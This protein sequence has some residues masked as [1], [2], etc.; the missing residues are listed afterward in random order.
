MLF[1]ALAAVQTVLSVGT[2]QAIEQNWIM[3]TLIETTGMTGAIAIKMAIPIVAFL[4]ARALITRDSGWTPW[5][6]RAFGAGAIMYALDAAGNLYAMTQGAYPDSHL[7]GVE[8]ALVGVALVCSFGAIVLTRTHLTVAGEGVRTHAKP[9]GIVVLVGMLVFAPATGAININASSPVGTATASSG[10]TEVSTY[11]PSD[12]NFVAHFT[13]DGSEVHHRIYD[14]SDNNYVR[15]D[16]TDGSVIGSTVDNSFHGIYETGGGLNYAYADDSAGDRGIAAYDNDGNRVWEQAG[17]VGAS[18]PLNFIEYGESSD[19]VYFEQTDSNNNGGMT[20]VDATDGTV[21][22]ENS[23]SPESLDQHPDTGYLWTIDNSD[24]VRKVDPA[25]GS[26]LNSYALSSSV[27]TTHSAA[28]DTERDNFWITN[29]NGD[30]YKVPLGGTS[31]TEVYTNADSQT[32]TN[33]IRQ[34]IKYSSTADRMYFVSGND[35]GDID[36]TDESVQATTAS[37]QPQQISI[38]E[39][40]GEIQ[41]AVKFGSVKTTVFSTGVETTDGVSGTVTSCDATTYVADKSQCEDTPVADTTVEVIAVQKSELSPDAGES[42]KEAA[43]EKLQQAKNPLPPSWDA[44]LQ[45][46]GNGGFFENQN[47]EY[48]AIHTRDDW[49]MSGWTNDANLEEPMVNPP[50]NEEIVLSAWDPSKN[51]IAQDNAD[52]DL[53][54]A[55]VKR[56]IIVERLSPSGDVTDRQVI[57]PDT[58]VEFA[59]FGKTHYVATTS[60]P[61][62]VYRVYPEGNAVSAYTVVAGNPDDLART[63]KK[64]LEDQSGN[65]EDRAASVQEQLN[66][67][68]FARKT[69]T[70][71][72]NGD[73]SVEVPSGTVVAH[74]QA[75]KIDGQVLPN[76]NDPS[77]QSMVDY[78]EN[79]DYN[80]SVYVSPKPQEY[81]PPTTSAD[82]RVVKVESPGAIDLQQWLDKWNAFRDKLENGTLA[83]ANGLFTD[84]QNKSTEDLKDSKENATQTLEDCQTDYCTEI[85]NKY[86]QI[87]ENQRNVDNIAEDI[88][89]LEGTNAELRQ[90][91]K[92]LEEAIAQ[93]GTD[94]SSEPAEISI[95][96]PDA[97]DSSTDTDVPTVDFRQP[98]DAD[99]ASDD[100]MVVWQSADGTTTPVPAEYWRVESSLVGN[101]AVVVEDYP[102]KADS[103]G[104]HLSVRV[105]SEDGLARGGDTVENPAFSGTQP[106]IRSVDV[107]S[108]RPGTGETVTADVNFDSAGVSVVDATVYAPD[109]TTVTST[110][111]NGEVEFTPSKVGAHSIRITMQDGSNNN[112]TETVGVVADDAS[113]NYPP[114]IKVVDG[115]TGQYVVAGDG[116]NDAA[117]DTSNNGQSV[118]VTG[119]VTKNADINQMHVYLEGASL[120]DGTVSVKMLEGTDINVAESMDTRIGVYIHT[121]SLKDNA[122]VYRE[123]DDPIPAG[124]ELK[125]GTRS[126]NDQNTVIKTYT[127]ANGQINVDINND[128]GRIESTWFDLQVFLSGTSPGGLL[129]QKPVQSV[130]TIAPTPGFSLTV[131]DFPGAIS[132]VLAQ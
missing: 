79:Q 85:K 110:V 77:P 32:N 69:T 120:A 5:M 66:N 122:V 80:G 96:V 29:E 86:E 87:L 44:D 100:V 97:T 10:W 111:S 119:L 12:D 16:P 20:A 19:R 17:Q 24:T 76:Q 67:G 101:D 3:N 105:M 4:V 61:E 25:D 57:S 71:D 104:G 43:E 60:L 81:E 1:G 102:I 22:W 40:N 13:D 121:S 99:I 56:D 18:T 47:V 28:I 64:D 35:Y 45:L 21:V 127:D 124:E 113:H 125:G 90:E 70:T 37:T 94:V 114:S 89:D 38:A 59:A 33:T 49:G 108:L 74:V 53:H 98:F 116:L 2:K 117:V 62:G 50:A 88:S 132:E 9:I 51:G 15:T 7:L 27:G 91:L 11:N 14:G 123:G 34:T 65:L 126:H 75:Y 106:E 109:G 112:F 82:V 48:A 130:L 63:I 118:S 36:L 95:E 78:V 128:P 93:Q 131:P 84:I 68:T 26:V 31:V 41:A 72:S 30:I 55:S 107:S 52:D 58:K 54:G 83:A 39:R 129:V 46:A 103:A 23:R 6:Q 115:T 92:A 73:Y 8:I 42:Y